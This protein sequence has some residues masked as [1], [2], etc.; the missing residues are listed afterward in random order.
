MRF[1]S[2]AV[3]RG[4]PFSAQNSVRLNFGVYTFFRLIVLGV[5]DCGR[6][7]RC[8]RVFSRF[9]RRPTP[10]LIVWVYAASGWLFI[11]SSSFILGK[12]LKLRTL[13]FKRSNL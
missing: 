2:C 8:F 4:L 1:L 7:G 11:Q 9:G 12:T 10:S 13:Q 6:D 5:P 3:F